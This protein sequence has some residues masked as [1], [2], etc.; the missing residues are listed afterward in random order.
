MDNRYNPHISVDCAIFG[1]DNDDLKILLIKRDAG[2]N[3]KNI[4]YKLPGDMIIRKEELMNSARRILKQYTGLENIYLKQFGVFDDPA[5][6]KNKDDLQWLQRS[7]EM[8][9]SRVITIAFYSLIKLDKSKKT[10]LSIEYGARWF[11]VK[12]IPGLIF[13]HNMILQKAI[14]TVKKEFLTDPLCFELLPGKFPLNQ[15][16][17]LCEVVLDLQLDNRNFRKKVLKLGYVEQLEEKQK[18]VKHKP[19]R[20]YSFNREIFNELEQ[21]KTGLVI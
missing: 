15:L 13:D 9:I 8:D 2:D 1:F 16:Q 19:A 5:R 21:K 18:G 6:L 12:K 20:L 11:S 3:G 7:T 14:D 17:K 4:R 10:E